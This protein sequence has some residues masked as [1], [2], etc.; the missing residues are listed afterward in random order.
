MKYDWSSFGI[1]Q[2]SSV[3]GNKI[4]QVQK[5]IGV[6][7]PDAYLDLV[8]Y[9]D[10]ASPEISSFRYGDGETCISEFF[11]FSTELTPYTISWYLGPGAPPQL[12]KGMIP[13]ARDAGGSLICLN[14]ETPDVAVEI[15]DPTSSKTY[16]VASSF[17]DFI[18]SW[19]E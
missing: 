3:D 2:G 12:P 13:I 19:H 16:V 17:D 15:F 9:A 10:E 18:N 6:V 1:D 5:T 4:S 7:F 8:A 14:F 11:P